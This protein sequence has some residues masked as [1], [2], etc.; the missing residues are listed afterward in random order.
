MI[1]TALGHVPTG[2]QEK[3]LEVF[4]LFLTD[5]MPESV[6]TLRGSAGTGKTT[7]ASAIVKAM[8]RLKQ[9]MILMAPTGRAAKV[10]SL[11]AEQPAYTIHRR[12]YRQRSAADLSSFSL[13]TNL[14]SDTLFIIDEASMISTCSA[15]EMFG[16]GS[17]LGLWGQELQD[18]THR[19]YRP[20]ASR[21]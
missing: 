14:H 20:V 18:A 13:N 19:R 2:D 12:I 17:L 5:R 7:L 9:K 1:R 3:A 21:R 8:T 15:N 6:M 11:Y 10:F 16:T 4:A